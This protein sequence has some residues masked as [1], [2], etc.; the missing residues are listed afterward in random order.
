MSGYENYLR[1]QSDQERLDNVAELKRAIEE[2]GQ[3]PTRHLR[4]F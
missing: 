4:S 1:L 3:D 2:E